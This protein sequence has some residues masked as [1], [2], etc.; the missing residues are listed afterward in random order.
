MT[1]GAVSD[2]QTA[3]KDPESKTELQKSSW[4]QICCKRFW[5]Y[6]D[7]SIARLQIPQSSSQIIFD[8]FNSDRDFAIALNVLYAGFSSSYF[9]KDILELKDTQHWSQAFHTVNV[10]KSQGPDNIRGC[11]IKHCA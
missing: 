11:L 8:G 7:K 5:V 6:L 10:N 4:M 2:F 1:E 3:T 9:S